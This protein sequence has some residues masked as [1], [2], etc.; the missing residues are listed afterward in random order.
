MPDLARM[1]EHGLD[2]ADLSIGFNTDDMK[3]PPFADNGFMV[4][5]ATRVRNGVGIPVGVSWNL[6]VPEYADRVIREEL[7]DLATLGRPALANP[8]APRSRTCL[9][10]CASKAPFRALGEASAGGHTVAVTSVAGRSR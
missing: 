5:R 3:L 7:I 2:L 9:T 1:K 4:E 8:P 6:G 10:K